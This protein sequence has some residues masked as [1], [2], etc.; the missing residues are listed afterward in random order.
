MVCKDIRKFISLFVIVLLVIALHVHLFNDTPSG[1][2]CCQI[3]YEVI[4]SGSNSCFLTNLNNAANRTLMHHKASIFFI[5]MS[6]FLADFKFPKH[7]KMSFSI[8]NNQYPVIS[9]SCIFRPKGLDAFASYSF[10]LF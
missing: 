4:F 6:S 9:A 3:L 10:Q 1:V 8:I 2:I 5:D 7:T